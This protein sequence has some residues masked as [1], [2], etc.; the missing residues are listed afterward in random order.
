[1]SIEQCP[2]GPKRQ[3]N[4]SM[5]FYSDDSPGMKIPPVRKLI[6][7]SLLRVNGVKTRTAADY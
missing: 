7:R 2:A 5:V 6:L 3:N 4:N 1:M